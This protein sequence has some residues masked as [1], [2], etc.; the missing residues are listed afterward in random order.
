MHN[1][2][3]KGTKT[4]NNRCNTAPVPL[5][6]VQQLQWEFLHTKH[7]HPGVSD[8]FFFGITN[9][10][11]VMVRP[12]KCACVEFFSW[13]YSFTCLLL[14]HCAVAAIYFLFLLL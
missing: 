14:A 11:K 10:V 13:W 3:Q 12:L 5:H 8:F 2:A 4:P 9:L 6:Q 1:H 7:I